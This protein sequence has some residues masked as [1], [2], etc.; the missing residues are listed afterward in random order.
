MTELTSVSLSDGFQELWAFR[1]HVHQVR[2][3]GALDE[4]RLCLSMDGRQLLLWDPARGLQH[5]VKFPKA[6]ENFLS[7]AVYIPQ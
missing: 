4:G 7:A 3:M 5:S 2:S 1:G 6:Q